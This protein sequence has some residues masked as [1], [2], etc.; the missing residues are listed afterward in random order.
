M[1]E[2]IGDSQISRIKPER[3]AWG[4]L[5]I[6]FAVFCVICIT[7][8]IGV[9]YFFFQSSVP[10]QAELVVGRGTIG[11]TELDMIP[12]FE[13]QGRDLTN[14]TAIVS[15][16]SQSQTTLSFRA[17]GENELLIAAV[18]LK[19]DSSF[20]L[21]SASLPR[22]EWS[23]G[24]YEIELQDFFGELEILVTDQSER[25][26]L[27]SVVT[28]DEA[29][30]HIASEGHYILSAS[31]I[32]VRVVNQ[33]G[34][35]V[36]FAPN[37]EDNR[38]IPSGQQGTLLVDSHDVTLSQAYTNLLINASFDTIV[39]PQLAGFPPERWG[40]TNT[41]DELPRG[42]Y[43]SEIQ[44]GR[45]VLRLVRRDGADSHG[46]TLC[47]QVFAE[48]GLDVSPYNYLAL[49]ATLLIEYQSLSTCGT[50][51]SECPL[52]L[53]MDYIDVSGNTRQWF[54]GFYT[55]D[56]PAL[57]YPTICD[58]CSQD[59]RQINEKAWYTFDTDNLFIVLPPDRKPASILNI[60]F[61]AQGHE[62]DVYV[63][64]IALVAGTTENSTGNGG[65]T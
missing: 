1:S 35:T 13:R 39:D 24:G 61:Y 26:F 38:S 29:R 3:L 19:G 31:D 48:T 47:R 14:L 21:V 44:D 9:Y 8:S 30:I 46:E 59:H 20:S 18:T 7:S 10:M 12:R 4:V 52:M 22:F 56:D 5:L 51:G 34:E 28:R 17:P 53:K 37:L 6:S 64:E 32:Q 60:W 36:L 42:Q 33:D 55:F 63:G 58:S 57:A 15:T 43:V 2:I 25:N 16:D 45:G 50:Q 62:Y 49:R 40:C 11:I 23:S 27:L 65:G 41:Q 54:Q